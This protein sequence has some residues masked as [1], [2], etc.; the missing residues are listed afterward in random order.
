VSLAGKVLDFNNQA[1][2]GLPIVIKSGAS[3]S[4]STITDAN[5]NFTAANVPTPYD[6]TVVV[7]GTTDKGA[8]VYIGLTGANPVLIDLIGGSATTSRTASLSGTLTGGIGFPTPGGT[9]TRVIFESPEVQ[10]QTSTSSGPYSFSNV[11]WN[12]PAT[13]TPGRSTC[14]S[15]RLGAPAQPAIRATAR[16]PASRSSTWGASAA[17]TSHFPR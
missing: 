14:C 12:G 15:G 10:D 13:T 2:T 9:L 6:V 7:N 3:F 4:V 1:R 16:M 5:G 17:R 11:S 8:T